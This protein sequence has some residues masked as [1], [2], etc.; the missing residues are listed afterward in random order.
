MWHEEEEEYLI[1]HDRR[2]GRMVSCRTSRLGPESL[3][4]DAE[5]VKREW[6]TVWKYTFLGP[7][8]EVLSE[9]ISPY[10]HSLHPYVFKL[11]PY[12]DGEVHS[13]VADIIDQQRHTNRLIT[14]YDWIMRST[15]KGVLLFPDGSLPD[16]ADFEEVVDQWSRFNGVIPYKARNGIPAPQQVSSTA[17]CGGIADLL[18]IQ[19]QMFEDISGVNPALQGKLE[20]AG[21]S[22]TLFSQQTKNALTS[23]RDIL[24]SFKEFVLES[25]RKDACNLMKFYSPARMRNVVGE[26]GAL[27]NVDLSDFENACL[28]FRFF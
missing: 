12:V 14:L 23:L 18:N 16:G 20:S 15:A 27:I 28:E 11:Y 8:G 4:P 21:V 3:P 22:G 2:R 24:E 26:E 1:F 25:T 19:L 13:F 7:S 9:G 17:R 10:S 5:Q 6:R